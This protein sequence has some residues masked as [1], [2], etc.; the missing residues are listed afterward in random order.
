MM[1]VLAGV[2]LRL[3]LGVPEA[4]SAH[5]RLRRRVQLPSQRLELAGCQAAS[6]RAISS[7][8]TVLGAGLAGT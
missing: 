2:C 7:R 3:R 1:V 5:G 4:A 8:M 6:T